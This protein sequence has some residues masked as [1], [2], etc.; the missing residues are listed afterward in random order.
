MKE[1]AVTM[2]LTHDKPENAGVENGLKRAM[3]MTDI[4][5]SPIKELAS[6]HYFY[7]AEGK[8]YAQTF[9]RP[10]TPMTG[11]IYSSVLKN[12]KFLGYN[13]SLETY[14]TA[15]R[16]PQSVLYTKN[17]HGT[18]RNN[19]GCWYG[20]VCS[21]FA[22][23]VHDL[24][25][26]TICRDWPFVENVT[27]L[28]Q[29]DP[30]TFKLLDIVL[31]TK[32]HIAVI[33][34]ILRDEDG[35]AKFIQVSEATLPQCKKTYFTPE[36]FKL[37][38]YDN[39]FNI[40]RRPAEDLAK[41]TYT[42]NIFVHISADPERGITE[43]PDLGTYEYNRVLLPNQG[44]ASNYSMEDDVVIDVLCDSVQSV[45]V[46]KD[47]GSFEETLTVEDG[48]AAVP[49]KLP[50]RYRAAAVYP[51]GEL[52]PQV[53]WAVT[54]LKLCGNK[55]A[56]APGETAE[57]TFEAEDGVDVFMENINRVK[58]SGEVTRAFLADSEKKAGKYTAK[59]PEEPGE[60]FAYVSAR[61]A[62]GV[63]TSN[64]FTFTVE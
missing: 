24:K 41:I 33:T 18:G 9:V 56:Y 12:Q 7:T 31:H 44:N 3:Q 64:H 26:R 39:E 51:D 38:W 53:E 61:N 15:L 27:M 21:C 57:F 62:Y 30:D 19:V 50:G 5:W 37:F 25:N 14:M 2:I 6:S 32:K 28:G 11:M 47:D 35:R 49:I 55:T 63:Y 60:F 16:D 10:G 58:T 42:P 52:S 13:V 17:L 1:E 40:Y 34:D 59:V 4:R 23:Y 54:E 20:I 8:T 48:K 36:E 22:S 45:K 29:P 43:D 46:T